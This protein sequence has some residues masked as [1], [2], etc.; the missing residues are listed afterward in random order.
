MQINTMYQ[1]MLEIGQALPGKGAEPTGR[2][3]DLQFDAMLQEQAQASQAPRKDKEGPAAQQKPKGEDPQQPAEEETMPTQ[4]GYAVAASLVT[5][6]PVVNL[7]VENQ[8]AQIPVAL[9]PV[10][11]VQEEA[12]V[13]PGQPVVI[14]EEADVP[15]LQ[16]GV[17]A[18]GIQ[19]QPQ[20]PVEAAHELELE[21]EAGQQAAPVE[22][23]LSQE[24]PELEVEPQRQEA[25]RAERVIHREEAPVQEE[26]PQEAEAQGTEVQ[27]R[28]MFQR[29]DAVPVKVAEPYEPVEPETVEA[30]QQLADRLTQMLEQGESRV[31]IALS[32]ENLGRMTVEITR[33]G[34]G[35]L[36]VVLGAA[37]EKVTALLQQNS[38]NLH[39]LLAANNQG[40]V[41]IQVQ[42]EQPA[43]E[44][45]NPFMNPDEGRGQQQQQQH[46]PQQQPSEDFVQQLRLGLVDRDTQEL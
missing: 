24:Q 42:Q 21:P 15:V 11:T 19:E 25:P 39:S 23:N 20:A 32:P 26:Q 12:A 6:Q 28:P 35:A 27:A 3:E 46:K 22:A 17:T 44:Q 38:S 30:P 29:E 4:A 10:G 33:T 16:E 14:Q 37:S 8:G 36:H 43:Q 18:S 34:D 1:A 13:L 5:S 31:E 45:P 7:M 2:E 40:E 9:D 41:H